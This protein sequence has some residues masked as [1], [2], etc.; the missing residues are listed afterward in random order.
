M[1]DNKAY[2][3]IAKWNNTLQ[4]ANTGNPL[5]IGVFLVIFFFKYVNIV[6]SV[7]IHLTTK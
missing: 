4:A 7:N 3:N 2:K 1:S 5:L 6:I